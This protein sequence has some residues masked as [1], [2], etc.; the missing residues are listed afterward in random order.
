MKRVVVVTGAAGRLGLALCRQLAKAGNDVIAVYR[1]T[2]PDV[3]SQLKHPPHLGTSLAPSGEVYC[4]CADLSIPEGANRVIEIGLARFRRIDAIVNAAADT[5]FHGKTLDL[6]H[7]SAAEE[8]QIRTNV[9]G[10]AYVVSAVF[11]SFWKDERER[12]QAANRSVVNVS[13]YSGFYAFDGSGQ[14]FYAVS[15]AALNMLTLHM[16]LELA[17]YGI[18]VNALCPPRFVNDSDTESVVAA[19]LDMIDGEETGQF[20][21]ICSPSSP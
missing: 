13:S 10:P 2:T 5:R 6:I 21:T 16:A 3:P 7:A 17:P 20:Q 19:I 4:V 12:N 15:K 11:H 9:F 1:S 14:A 18:R 8:G